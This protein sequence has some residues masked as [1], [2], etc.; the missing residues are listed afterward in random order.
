MTDKKPRRVEIMETGIGLTAGDRNKSYGSPHPNL[1]TFAALVEAYLRGLGW[2]GPPLDS[3]DGSMI[4]VQAKV[5]RVAANKNHADNYVDGSTYFGIGGECAELVEQERFVTHLE[6]DAEDVVQL[7]NFA[8]GCTCNIGSKT[9]G[10]HH[11]HKCGLYSK[12]KI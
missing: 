6:V 2:S 3:V 5:S 1:T 4:M 12:H 7:P 9:G 10:Q 11:Y 8:R